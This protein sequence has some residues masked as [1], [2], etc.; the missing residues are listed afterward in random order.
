MDLININILIK[1]WLLGLVKTNQVSELVRSQDSMFWTRILGSLP[2]NLPIDNPECTDNISQV[3][4]IF[5]IDRMIIGHTPQSFLLSKDIN[6]TCGEKIWRVDN[7]SSSA[8]DTFDRH[9]LEHKEK[10]HNR[11]LQYLEI[12]NDTEYHVYD[13][14][15]RVF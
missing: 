4:K 12:L 10:H 9:F 13:S 1:K 15:G 14:E 7:G 11:R 3:L 5:N 6:G 8:F 2:P